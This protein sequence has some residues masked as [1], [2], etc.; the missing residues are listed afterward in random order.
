MSDSD[1]TSF[2]I[3]GAGSWG[4]ALAI[5]LARNGHDVYLWGHNTPHIET[6]QQQ[7][8]NRQH[9]PGISFPENL[10]PVSDVSDCVERA[11]NCLIAV[12]SHAFRHVLEQII[13]TLK[14]K[15]V[16]W[17]TKGIEP[18]SKKLIHEIVEEKLGNQHIMAV[19][20]GP[21]FAQEVAQ[22]L[23]TAL[24]VASNNP[25]FAEQLAGWLHGESMRAYTSDDIIGVEIGGAIK[26][27]LAIAAGIADGLGFGANTRSALITR[28]LHEIMMLGIALGGKKETFMGLAGLGDLVLTCTDNQSRNRRLGLALA[29]GKTMQQALDEIKQTVEG[30]QT[31]E[32][33]L[34]LA[35]KYNIEMPITQQV[36]NVLNNKIT[37]RDAVH[38]LLGREQK[39]E[40]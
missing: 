4:T 21:T 22:G 1:K 31:T 25:A 12:P 26:N 3:L 6:L 16:I 39:S 27:V 9:L 17:A 14:N 28:G 20:S 23:P 24:T 30:I 8:E 19:I 32:E 35:Q 5:L 29:Q 13:S 36:S 37:A 33:A 38:L 15:P 7:K 2:S 10:H 18:D 11:S 34:G 40:A